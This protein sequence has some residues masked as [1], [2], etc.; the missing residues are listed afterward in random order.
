MEFDF[1]YDLRPDQPAGIDKVAELLDL[2]VT[3][4][5]ITAN[6]AYYYLG[7]QLIAQGRRNAIGAIRLN[8][9]L[10]FEL[11]SQ[12]M[13]G[14][15]QQRD[16]NPDLTPIAGMPALPMVSESFEKPSAED[17]ANAAGQ[18]DFDVKAAA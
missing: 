9:S 14:K 3:Q 7:P 13:V 5:I 4:R 8:R 12:I 11:F 18:D 6:G 17:L 16:Y 2:A 1:L 15:L 10:M